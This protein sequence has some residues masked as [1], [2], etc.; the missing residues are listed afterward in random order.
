LVRIRKYQN[1]ISFSEGGRRQLVDGY[2]ATVS[3]FVRKWGGKDL[4]ADE[5]EIKAKQFFEWIEE[6]LNHEG[7][8]D[9]RR[10]WSRARAAYFAQPNRLAGILSFWEK[11][12]RSGH[13]LALLKEKVFG[14]DLPNQ[15]A[16]KW[17]KSYAA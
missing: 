4:V 8:F 6:Q 14:S 2:A 11:L 12:L 5:N 7:V 15:L 1:Q 9:R 10:A 16:E 3:Y 13:A 17:L